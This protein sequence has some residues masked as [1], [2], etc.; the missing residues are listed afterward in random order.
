MKGFCRSNYLIPSWLIGNSIP[1]KF[2]SWLVALI[3]IYMLEVNGDGMKRC[4][5]RPHKTILILIFH[6]NDRLL[7]VP[8]GLVPYNVSHPVLPTLCCLV[9][10]WVVGTFVVIA[11]FIKNFLIS[12]NSYVK[13]AFAE[14]YAWKPFVD[15]LRGV[16]QKCRWV[17]T[18]SVDI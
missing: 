8:W 15:V 11:T 13:D 1:S 4:Q 6:V 7:G 12:C 17:V 16:S 2:S 18:L 3:M 5:H 14:W 9:G 10:L